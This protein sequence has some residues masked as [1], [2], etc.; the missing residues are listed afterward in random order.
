VS[1]L[2]LSK[3]SRH[4]CL[5][6]RPL[7]AKPWY[8]HQ[9]AETADRPASRHHC[10]RIRYAAK[11]SASLLRYT[12]AVHDRARDASGNPADLRHCAYQTGPTGADR[13]KLAV[14]PCY[15]PRFAASPRWVVAYDE[16]DGY[17]LVSGGQPAW[18]AEEPG[19]GCTN[20]RGLVNAGL[21]ILLRTPERDEGL[22]RRVRDLAREKGFDLSVLRDVDQERCEMCEDDTGKIKA[23]WGGERDCAWVG[24]EGRSGRIRCHL[25]GDFCPNTCERC[26][27]Y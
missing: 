22:I 15:L 16:A 26:E 5:S 13:S 6:K 24:A 4:A 20:G 27:E 7:P 10:V 17:A 23:W 18:S 3:R 14:A 2:S 11:T 12:F 8:S 21:W 19:E 1:F 25:Y 9:Q